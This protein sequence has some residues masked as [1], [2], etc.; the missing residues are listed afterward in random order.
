MSGDLKNPG[1]SIPAG[2]FAAVFTGLL[3][4]GLQ[5]FI[6]GGAQTRDQLIGSSFETMGGLS[7]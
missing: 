6:I 7:V 4:Y 5:I 3:I 2:T 1:K